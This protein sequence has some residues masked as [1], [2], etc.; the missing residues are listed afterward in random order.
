M[1]AEVGADS[2]RDGS[3][4]WSALPLVHCRRAS[5]LAMST[6]SCLQVDAKARVTLHN[7]ASE[8]DRRG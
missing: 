4:L 7:A 6:S 5:S 8:V 2:L 3:T 1:D